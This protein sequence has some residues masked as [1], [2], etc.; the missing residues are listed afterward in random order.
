[1]KKDL[2]ACR[3]LVNAQKVIKDIETN[4]LFLSL[5]EQL[6]VYNKCNDAVEELKKNE[7]KKKF[8]ER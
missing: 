2:V 1:M 8:D 5:N 3:K 6:N 7:K 4:K